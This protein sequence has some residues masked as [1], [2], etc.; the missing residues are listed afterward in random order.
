MV[1]LSK[2]F[3]FVTDESG[4]ITVDWVVL[5]AALMLMGAIAVSIY[6]PGL[7]GAATDINDAVI[8][9]GASLTPVTT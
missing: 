4:A 6:R 7:D 2:K 9:V 3:K 8:N 1:F 5:T